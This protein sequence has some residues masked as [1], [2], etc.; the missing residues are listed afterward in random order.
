MSLD[1]SRNEVIIFLKLL[2]GLCT[3]WEEGCCKSMVHSG[4]QFNNSQNIRLFDPVVPLL[5][6]CPKEMSHKNEKM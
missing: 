3:E 4:T 6:I 5:G 2:L 1:S